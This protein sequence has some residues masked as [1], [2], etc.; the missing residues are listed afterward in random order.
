[1]NRFEAIKKFFEADGGKPLPAT[2]LKAFTKD[3][4]TELAILCAEALGVELDPQ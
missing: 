1:M 2:E 3:E 4:R